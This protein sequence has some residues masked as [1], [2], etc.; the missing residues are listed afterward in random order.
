MKRKSIYALCILFAAFAF[1]L[2]FARGSREID[3]DALR[4]PLT[5]YV[6]NMEV[7]DNAWLRKQ[8]HLDTA[9]YEQ[10][11]VYGTASA[12]EADEIAVF[13]QS[14][15]TKRKALL[16]LCQQRVDRQLKSFQG[17]APRQSALLEKASVYED[18][19]YVVVLIHPQQSQ[20]RQLLKKA[21]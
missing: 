20:L 5:P 6:T 3:L 7:K 8:Y 12:I 21:W 13:K 11:L 18:G 15:Q 16:K 2:P 17:Y 14:D 4:K 10:V 1:A 19:R 9:A